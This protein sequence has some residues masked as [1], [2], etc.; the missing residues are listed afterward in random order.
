MEKNNKGL[1]FGFAVSII[2]HFVLLGGAWLFSDK[3]ILEETSDEIYEASDV[4]AD[5]VP[6]LDENTIK[7]VQKIARRHVTQI[8]IVPI[9][10]GVLDKLLGKSRLIARQVEDERLKAQ[11]KT[12]P[13]VKNPATKPKLLY[14]TPVPYPEE[15]QGEVGTIVVC[16]LVGYDGVPEY[17]STAQ[18]SGN[19]FLDSAALDSCIKWRFAPAKDA[20]G[21]LV[22]CLVYIPITVKP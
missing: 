8:E 4:V 10:D 18:S 22:R 3:V 13:V 16:F 12:I 9:N 19:R 15:A 21:R 20:Q 14:R 6:E 5:F 7:N 17:T 2:L 11:R 1:L